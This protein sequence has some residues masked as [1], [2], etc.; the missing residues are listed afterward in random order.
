MRDYP[1]EE[2]MSGSDRMEKHTVL[3]EAISRIHGVGEHAKEILNRIG[4]PETSGVNPLDASLNKVGAPS[5]EQ[6][7][8][9]SPDRIIKACDEAHNTLDMIMG[10][11]F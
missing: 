5:L 7:L 10:K 2:M 9:E 1:E 4:M 6:V 8:D 11:L 3:N